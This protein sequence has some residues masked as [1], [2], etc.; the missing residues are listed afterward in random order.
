MSV[1]FISVEM[2]GS[3]PATEQ[4]HSN[5]FQRRQLVRL[6]LRNTEVQISIT[7]AT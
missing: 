7:C 1:N 2:S 6:G 4:Y 3:F 5:M